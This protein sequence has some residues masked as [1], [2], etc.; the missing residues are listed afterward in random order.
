MVLCQTQH[1]QELRACRCKNFIW[2]LVVLNWCLLSKGLQASKSFA[3]TE[4]EFQRRL[5]KNKNIYLLWCSRFS[6][7]HGDFHTT[8]T[9]RGPGVKSQ[10]HHT[11]PQLRII[12][13]SSRQLRRRIAAPVLASWWTRETLLPLTPNVLWPKSEYIVE[14]QRNCSSGLY[15]AR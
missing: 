12:R 3:S 11:F 5:R 2:L 9:I 8:S 15:P 13:V 1:P 7:A 14:F 4:N 6:V 10:G